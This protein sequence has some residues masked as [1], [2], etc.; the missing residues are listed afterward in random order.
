MTCGHRMI[1]INYTYN[2][3]EQN[4]LF[5]RSPLGFRKPKRIFSQLEIGNA[6]VF[7]WMIDSTNVKF[8]Y[9]DMGPK[10]NIFMIKLIVV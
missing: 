8:G 5:N 7:M 10:I 2:I 1:I 9:D 4:V 6:D 3:T